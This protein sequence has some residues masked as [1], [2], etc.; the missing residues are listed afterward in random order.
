MQLDE[1]LPALQKLFE[2]MASYSWFADIVSD[3]NRAH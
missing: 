1:D 3:T 2:K